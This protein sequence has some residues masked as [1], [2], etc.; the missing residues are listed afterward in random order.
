MVE[1]FLAG[2]V[3]RA[4][5]AEAFRRRL[6]CFQSVVQALLSHAVA[7]IHEPA[8]REH[9]GN[10]GDKGGDESRVIHDPVFL[11][12][13]KLLAIREVVEI[14]AVCVLVL[15]VALGPPAPAAPAVQGVDFPV[16][17]GVLGKVLLNGAGASPH[18][19]LA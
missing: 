16:V 19:Y 11:R 15:I 18:P 14:A 4:G 17:F 3:G 6:L 1:D 2:V 7:A 10:P 12:V 5:D 13:L 8:G 9:G